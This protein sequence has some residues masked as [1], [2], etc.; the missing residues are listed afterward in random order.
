L[1]IK[2]L[3]P[4]QIETVLIAIEKDNLADANATQQTKQK[5]KK[6]PD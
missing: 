1:K 3:S 5:K 4:E 2:Q 6:K